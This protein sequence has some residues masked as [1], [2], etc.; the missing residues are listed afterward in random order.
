MGQHTVVIT[1]QRH[2]AVLTGDRYSRAH[3][4]ILDGPIEVPASGS[5]VPSRA[6]IL[7]R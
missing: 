1:C 4:W 3:R 2:G 6:A 7:S 5:P